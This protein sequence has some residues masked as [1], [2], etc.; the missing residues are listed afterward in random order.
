ME[1]K[2]LFKAKILSDGIWVEGDLLHKG[3]KTY[4]HC[5]RINDRGFWVENVEVD[6]STVCQFTGL[7]DK[8]GKEVW[9]GDIVNSDNTLYEVIYI[10]DEGAFCYVKVGESPWHYEP[11]CN[12][13]AFAKVG[14]K[15]DRKEGE[16]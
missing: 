10:E 6:H 7:K 1:R 3:N 9:E 13:Y 15:F 8:D 2:I 12:I 4:I 5:P 11:L 14:S 16:K